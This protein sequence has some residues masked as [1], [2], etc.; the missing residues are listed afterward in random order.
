MIEACG[1][2]SE[3]HAAKIADLLGWR[4]PARDLGPRLVLPFFD[5]DGTPTGY[6]RAK[7]DHPRTD[8]EGKPVKYESPKAA[9]SPRSA[10][11][12]DAGQAVL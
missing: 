5:A 9:S 7:P 11:P 6:V 8:K 3:A 4:G 12:H 2:R 1:F 10:A